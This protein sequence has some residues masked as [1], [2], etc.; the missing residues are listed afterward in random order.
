MPQTRMFRL[1]LALP[2]LI[3]AC[4][5]DES[6]SGYA[7][8]D[9]TYVLQELNGTPFPAQATLRFPEPGK[10][11]GQGPCNSFFAAQTV[12]YP[13]IKIENIAATKRACPDLAQ[14]SIY[15]QILTQMTLAEALGNTLILSN[16]N[17]AEMVFK[18]E[19]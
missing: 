6:I 9:A 5:K 12:P 19:N 3:A 16:D 10:V 11:T 2:L 15:F 14:E 13:W 4:Q 17:G 7:N 18:S 8:P 1:L